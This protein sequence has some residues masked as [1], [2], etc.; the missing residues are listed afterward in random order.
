MELRKTMTD[1]LHINPHGEDSRAVANRMLEMGWKKDTSMTV[2]QLVKLVY[3]AH[4]WHLSLTEGVPL[5][6][7][8]PQ[9]WIYGPVYPPIYYG[10]GKTGSRPVTTRIIDK[11]TQ[12]DV[13]GDFSERTE[14]IMDQVVE[15]Y[16]RFHAF[17]L[18]DMT[19]KTGTP[20]SIITE[21][22]GRYSEIPDSLIKEHFDERRKQ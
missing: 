6:R 3:I 10:C 5:T 7:D 2:M 16:G 20:W 1:T 11:I 12:F 22:N 4:G 14:N 21:N 15:S 9:A 13:V 19:H 8:K 18:S 17:T